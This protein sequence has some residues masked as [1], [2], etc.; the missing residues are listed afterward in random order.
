MFLYCVLFCRSHVLFVALL[1]RLSFLVKEPLISMGLASKIKVRDLTQT[2]VSWNW[3][4]HWTELDEQIRE[5]M[6]NAAIYILLRS[7][8]KKNSQQLPFVC[9]TSTLRV[10]QPVHCAPLW[11]RACGSWGWWWAWIPEPAVLLPC[12]SCLYST[13]SKKAS[14]EGKKS[15]RE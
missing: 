8:N 1:G 11:S 5:W 3:L 6:E 2:Q 9:C 10:W 15:K 14:K 13:G 7:A 4:C 12:I